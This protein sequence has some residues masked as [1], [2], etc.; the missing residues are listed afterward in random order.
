MIFN[1]SIPF[2]LHESPSSFLSCTNSLKTGRRLR[3][4]C[5]FDLVVS[6]CCYLRKAARQCSSSCNTLMDLIM[7]IIPPIRPNPPI[8]PGAQTSSKDYRFARL[9]LPGKRISLRRSWSWRATWSRSTSPTQPG[10]ARSAIKSRYARLSWNVSLHTTNVHH[11]HPWKVNLKTKELVFS[12]IP[13][14]IVR[15]GTGFTNIGFPQRRTLMRLL[16]IWSRKQ[17]NSSRR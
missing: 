17:L 8:C 12:A 16:H 5:I 2:F 14:L 4:V 10:G 6:P 7:I 3:K 11:L 9:S 15:S 1:I 13:V